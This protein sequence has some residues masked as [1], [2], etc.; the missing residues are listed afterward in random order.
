[1]GESLK[2]HNLQK[3]TQ[4]YIDELNGPVSTGYVVKHLSFH[5]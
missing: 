2:R 5:K 1:M 4:E 3:L